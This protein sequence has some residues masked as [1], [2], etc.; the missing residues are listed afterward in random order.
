MAHG[1]TTL[2][3]T[4]V[5]QLKRKVNF[6]QSRNSKHSTVERICLKDNRSFIKPKGEPFESVKT[7]SKHEEAV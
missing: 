7:C 3:D 6:G 5:H 4:C 2:C 1:E